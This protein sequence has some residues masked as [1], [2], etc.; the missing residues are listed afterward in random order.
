MRVVLLAALIIGA[1]TLWADV[2]TCVARYNVNAYLSGTLETVDIE[3]LKSLGDGA[4]PYIRRLAEEAPD[5]VVSGRAKSY[6]TKVT[7][8]GPKDFRDWNYVNHKAPAY[9]WVL[10]EK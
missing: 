5:V 8:Y 9:R 4:L 6:L 1:A 7:E 3:H 2:D 10:N